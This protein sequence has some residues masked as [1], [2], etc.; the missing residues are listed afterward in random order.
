M[1]SYEGSDPEGPVTLLD[2]VEAGD[3]VHIDE[4]LRFCEAELHQRDQALASGEDLGVLPMLREELE[5]LVEGLGPVVLERCWEHP[6]PP[7]SAG[8]AATATRPL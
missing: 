5:R 2:R 3:P 8:V 1:V 7:I 4:P 6:E